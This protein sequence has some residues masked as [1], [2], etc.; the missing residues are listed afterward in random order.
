MTLQNLVDI[1]DKLVIKSQETI[2]QLDLWMKQK[3]CQDE[4]TGQ[5]FEDEYTLFI[6]QLNSLFIRSK[7]VRDK[8]NQKLENF[9]SNNRA[10]STMIEN[11]DDYVKHLVFE[12]KDITD[13]LNKLSQRQRIIVNT[14]SSPSSQTTDSS[15]DSFQPKPLKIYSRQ[16]DS[17]LLEIDQP[18]S[19]TQ[20]NNGK[21]SDQL[22]IPKNTFRSLS[23][24]NSLPS[25]PIKSKNVQSFIDTNNH[26]SSSHFLKEKTLRSTK[27]YTD[28]LN[29][30][31]S[32]E[33]KNSKHIDNEYQRLF[34]Q[35]NRLSLSLVGEEEEYT[36]TNE[37]QDAD[38]DY[39]S[40]D[41]NEYSNYDS[42]Q[43]TIMQCNSPIINTNSKQ[44]LEPLR[45]YNSHESILST[46]NS[47]LLEK[48]SKPLKFSMFSTSYNNPTT[49]ISGSVQI[50]S[51]PIFAR[52]SIRTSTT[53][54]SQPVTQRIRSTDL[55]HSV[56][57]D[58][59]TQIRTATNDEPQK[60][61]KSSFFDSWN[62][63]NRYPLSLTSEVG[64]DDLNNV[65][66]SNITRK[67]NIQT[68]RKQV[69]NDTIVISTVISTTPNQ[70]QLNH[71]NPFSNN[72]YC[73]SNHR[74]HKDTT[75]CLSTNFSE[76]TLE[77]HKNVK[78]SDLH[79]AL[80]TELIL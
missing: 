27:S 30:T 26:K 49:A 22:I 41:Y 12:Y 55:L 62:V 40:D 1:S 51:N 25:S 66:P 79:E 28:G 67:S 5:I 65:I 54:H 44:Q 7:Y 61:T 37:S 42:D 16:R 6:A 20:K 57:K 80:D 19:N 32:E 48:K 73:D 31:K 71:R 75:Q 3:K 77:S 56:M 52:T 69:S 9:N 15:N 21:I 33:R 8:L 29:I 18:I 78:F 58:M 46:R 11:P 4:I 39:D 13:K 14:N 45:R 60:P 38:I 72:A 74:K 70:K 63:F 43:N 23:C 53:A 64:K 35:K 34:K 10:S 2:L 50:N 59:N 24:H 47:I 17:L 76:Y 68:F 36:R